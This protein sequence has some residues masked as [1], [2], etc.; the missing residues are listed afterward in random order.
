MRTSKRGA[1]QAGFTLIE[2]I[3]FIVVVAVGAVGILTVMNES[4]GRSADPMLRKQALAL[5]DSI[6]EEVLSK[7][8]ADPDGT[9][10][11]ETGRV[12]WDDVSDYNGKTN[13]DFAP[14][15]AS[16]TSYVIGIAVA[17]DGVTLG[18]PALRVTVTI[19]YGTE[20]IVMTGYRTDY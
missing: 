15:P 2:L 8:F 18:V 1:R 17:N 11:G 10:V 6:L 4:V 13:A 16:L 12:D 7:S 9:N 20:A 14:L 5:A 3:F 19:T